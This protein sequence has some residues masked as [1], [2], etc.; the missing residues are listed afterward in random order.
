MVFPPSVV[1][2]FVA[3]PPPDVAV[4]PCTGEPAVGVPGP[5]AMDPASAFV[6]AAAPMDEL[7]L[8][9]S[10]LAALF[11]RS[12]NCCAFGILLFVISFLGFG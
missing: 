10:C 7:E 12:S 8:W 6:A 9:L 5:P 11:G 2:G 3:L 1:S 4:L